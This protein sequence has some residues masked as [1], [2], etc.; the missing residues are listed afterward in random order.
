VDLYPAI[1]LRGGRCV[2]LVEGDFGREIV[3][4]DDPVAV[5]RAFQAAGARWIHV[6]DLDAA[7]TGEPTNRAVVARIAAA[8]AGGG[9]DGGGPGVWVQT[10]GGVRSVDDAAELFAAGVTRVVVGTAAVE[11]PELVAEIAARWPDGV[12]VGLDHRD[13]ELRVRGWTEGGGRRVEEVVP[14]VMETGATA[15]I[16]TDIS[17]DGRLTGPD[18]AGLSSLLQRT[19]APIIASGGVRDLAD[20]RALAGVQAPGPEGGRLAGV[21]AGTAIYEGRLDVAATL[22]A[23][24]AWAEGAP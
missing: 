15:V 20:V 1:D 17:R 6:V 4:G 23:L 16:V 7:R 18:V 3:Y 9:S 22:A 11:R 12:A 13:G 10:G 21:I 19:G 14:E 24:A 5:A 8:V 2:R